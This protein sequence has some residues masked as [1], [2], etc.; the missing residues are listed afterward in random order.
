MKILFFVGVNSRIVPSPANTGGIISQFER[1]MMADIVLSLR[2]GAREKVFIQKFYLYLN[3]TKPSDALYVTFSKVNASG[4]ALR[5]SYL[6]GT[7]QQ[8]FP[9]LVIAE[10]ESL[11][12][13]DD[14]L[15]PGK[16]AA[17]SFGR[18]GAGAG[19]R[20]RI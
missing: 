2:Q 14:V 15:A 20:L 6:I 18:T 19:E 16:C 4:K 10:Q 8:M 11:S 9:S 12:W 13:T 17:V 5:L 1:E 7:L 3:M